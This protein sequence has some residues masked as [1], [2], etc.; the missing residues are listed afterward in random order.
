MQAR[1]VP[2]I[3]GRW[4]IEV[5]AEDGDPIESGFIV[6]LGAMKLTTTVVGGCIILESSNNPVKKP[7]TSPLPRVKIQLEE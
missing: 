2:L 3:G 7:L 1:F 5:K 6:A 4:V